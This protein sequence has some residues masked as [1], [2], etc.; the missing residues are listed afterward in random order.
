MP[1]LNKVQYFIKRFLLFIFF[2]LSHEENQLHKIK[3]YFFTT[4][5]NQERAVPHIST[6]LVWLYE[7]PSNIP[8]WVWVWQIKHWKSKWTI[9]IE[10]QHTTAHH[11]ICPRP[12]T[13][14]LSQQGAPREQCVKG[15]CH[16]QC[17]SVEPWGLVDSNLQPS[18][19]IP[20][21]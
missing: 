13:H 12:L 19:P 21:P 1:L 16:A 3:K 5:S 17:T 14:H 4:N 18:S 7:P 9:V 8:V 2:P 11:D 20:L 10:A 6:I 15:Q